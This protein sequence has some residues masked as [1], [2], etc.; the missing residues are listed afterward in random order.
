MDRRLEFVKMQ[1][2]GNDYIFI[3]C[4]DAPVPDPSYLAIK[5]SDRHFGIGGDGAVFICPSDKADAKM[6]M[7]NRDGSEGLMCGNAVRCVGKYLYDVRGVRRGQITVE[8]LAGVRAL[9]MI[10]RGG[11]ATGARVMMGKAEFAPQNIPVL[12]TG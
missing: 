2:C 11:I 7:F 12:L 1:G 5:L 4:L 3:D 10:T 6:R 9:D 8:T